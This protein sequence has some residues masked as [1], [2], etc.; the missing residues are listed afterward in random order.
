M[1]W[2]PKDDVWLNVDFACEKSSGRITLNPSEY[3]S[4]YC[5]KLAHT[6]LSLPFRSTTKKLTLVI[7]LA[8]LCWL[9]AFPF[10]SCSKVL[11]QPP[12]AQQLH[13]HAQLFPMRSQIQLW[14]H[15]SEEKQ[16]FTEER[17]QQRCNLSFHAPN[18]IVPYLLIFC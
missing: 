15:S 5:G 14:S 11:V 2:C 3:I 9:H 8:A 4:N 12:L 18:A 1:S 17:L 6:S 7:G 10:C 13:S 16:S